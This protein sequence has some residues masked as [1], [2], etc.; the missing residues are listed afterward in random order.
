ML[1]WTITPEG[2][3]DSTPLVFE[4]A[5]AEPLQDIVLIDKDHPLADRLCCVQ[6]MMVDWASVFEI[7]AIIIDSVESQPEFSYMLHL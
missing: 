2:S 7:Q 5:D 4:N 6:I 1:V 3:E